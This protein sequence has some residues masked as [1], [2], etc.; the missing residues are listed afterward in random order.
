MAANRRWTEAV[1]DEEGRAAVECRRRCISGLFIAWN[2]RDREE[3]EGMSSLEAVD[4]FPA[5]ALALQGAASEVAVQG[6]SRSGVARGKGASRGGS[7]GG[8][9]CA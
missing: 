1:R 2:W 4:E 7:Q 8:R 9:A 5:A 6:S 3:E